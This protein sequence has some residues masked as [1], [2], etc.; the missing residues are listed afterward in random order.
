MHKP[1]FFLGDKIAVASMFQPRSRGGGNTAYP[2]RNRQEYAVEI[3]SQYLTAIDYA[4]SI[5]SDRAN[6][7]KPT[8]NGAYIDLDMKGALAPLSLPKTQGATIM[9]VS[10][11]KEDGNVAVTVYVE[12]EKKDWLSNKADE[13]AELQD[14]EKLNATD[15]I[16]AP[17]DEVRAADIRSLYISAE[18]FDAIPDD[19]IG[20]Y[21]LWLYKFSGYEKRLV[22]TVLSC[23][24]IENNDGRILEFDSVD[25]WLIKAT[26]QQLMEIPSS[27]DFIEGVRPYRQPSILTRRNVE[28]REWAELI[29]N[30]AQ[31]ELD[32]NSTR[33]GL[34]DS[35]VNNAHKL[36]APALPDERM[37]SVLGATDNIDHDNHGTGM[38]GLA[39]Y[40]DLTDIVYQRAPLD[41]IKHDLASVKIYEE[42][43]ESDTNFYGVIIEDG[44]NK[45]Q[46]LGANIQCMA[47]TD[48]TPYEGLP[49]SS[50][51]ALDVSIYHGGLCDR[52]VLVSA[53]NIDSP[54][55]DADDYTASCKAHSVKSPA[56]AWNALTVGAF[57]EKT[58]TKD[59]TFKPLAPPC[60]ISPLSRTSYQWK[61]GHTKPEIMMEG[62]N[63]AFHDSLGTT[64]LEDLSLITTNMDLQITLNEF[65][66]TSAATALA[67]RLAAKIKIANP[68]LS[69]LSIRGMMVHSA[70]W[71]PEMK[72]LGDCKDIMPLCGYGVPVEDIALFSNERC[73]TYIFENEITPFKGVKGTNIYNELHYY[74]L[75]WPKELLEQMG[76]ENVTIRITLSYYVEPSPG[77]AG[78]K[79]KYR[80]PSAM[81]GF[82]L[83]TPTES[84]SEFRKRH[85]KFEGEKTTKNNSNRWNIKQTLRENGTVQSDWI[86]CKAIELA[87][88]N[89]IV[90]YPRGGWWKERKLENVGNNIKYSLIV[91][92]ESEE[93]EIYNAVETAINNAIGIQTAIAT[94]L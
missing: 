38:A 26:K 52:L 29:G 67:A 91:S 51:S 89:E 81:L 39:L 30:D 13:Y 34:L 56:Q 84:A 33:L 57:T 53:G 6:D 35:G 24:G 3:K 21:E 25:V 86:K 82:D 43:H 1:H 48:A 78:K 62:G 47:V 79:N 45:A 12:K 83:N 36:L 87:A 68:Q 74:S 8:A 22:Q 61:T 77:Y 76:N 73:A 88:C 40:G 94:N 66:G 20:T 65:S 17:I 75:P 9:K 5:L 71:T 92:L 41:A 44:I 46:E 85:N 80:Y 4:I 54:D 90:V 15:K 58:A 59:A 42:G 2:A 50:S 63:Y 27:I 70:R 93:T 32:E 18:E 23:L 31:F 14:S 64:P 10:K 72:R 55:V 69:M 16:I 49:T 19:I 28:N 11:P 60:G 7:G 37:A